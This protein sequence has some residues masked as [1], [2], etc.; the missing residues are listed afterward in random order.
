MGTCVFVKEL[1][2]LRKS[3]N[4]SIDHVDKFDDFKKYMH[5]TRQAELDFPNVR[6]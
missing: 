1:N 2:K 6:L 5:V 3:S 4:E